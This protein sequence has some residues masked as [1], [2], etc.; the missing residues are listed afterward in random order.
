MLSHTP[1]LR[2]TILWSEYMEKMKMSVDFYLF[3]L[4]CV[5]LQA[6]A[7]QQKA[8]QL[9]QQ[10]QAGASQVQAAPSQTQGNAAGQTQVQVSQAT[11]VTSP[12]TVPNAA[13]LVRITT[14]TI[15][16]NISVAKTLT[17]KKFGILQAGGIKNATVGTT[18]QAG[19]STHLTLL[20][21]FCQL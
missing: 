11:A 13:V 16:I 9:A 8:Q 10:Q 1:A 18:I 14:H 2:S 3:F 21:C 4:H 7:E 17:L 6:L 20:D 19:M 15:K 12:A 5:C